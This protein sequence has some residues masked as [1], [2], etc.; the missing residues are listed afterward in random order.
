MS[1]YSA[2]KIGLL[3]ILGKQFI[4]WSANFVVLISNTIES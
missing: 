1:P 2:V 4:N 3:T